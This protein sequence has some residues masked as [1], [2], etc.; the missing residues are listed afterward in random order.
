VLLAAF[1]AIVPSSCSGGST[2]YGDEEMTSATVRVSAPQD[3][4]YSGFYGSEMDSKAVSSTI[5]AH[6][7]DYEIPIR[8]GYSAIS[9]V[10][11]KTK[12]GEEGTLKV[13]ILVDSKVVAQRSTPEDLGV[14]SVEWSAQEDPAS[15]ESTQSKY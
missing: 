12:E 13:Q 4:S 1:S 9:A 14:V 10:F 5:G 8:R 7:T 15:I 6:P 2:P 11:Q 3:T